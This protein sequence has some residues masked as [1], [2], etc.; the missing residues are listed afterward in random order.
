MSNFDFQTAQQSQ[1]FVYK[2]QQ[3]EYVWDKCIYLATQTIV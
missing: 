1:R 2:I 3:Q